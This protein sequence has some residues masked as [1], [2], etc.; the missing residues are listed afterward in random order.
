ME[1]GVGR[2]P[3]SAAEVELT[4]P[5]VKPRELFARDVARPG[6][7]SGREA[8][9]RLRFPQLA[10]D[11]VPPREPSGDGRFVG[12]ERDGTVMGGRARVVADLELDLRQER[13]M[14]RIG[15]VVGVERWPRAALR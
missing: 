3:L 9:D 6:Q 4:E 10:R 12:V 2:V 8:Q 1:R 5:V 11:L 13:G 14:T 7:P 15:G